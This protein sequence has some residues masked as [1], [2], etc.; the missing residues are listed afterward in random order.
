M[1]DLQIGL[2]VIGAVAVV[3]VVMFNR[4]QERKAHREAQRA[5]GSGHADVLLEGSPSREDPHLQRDGLQSAGAMPDE[6]IDY[7]IVLRAPVGVP[8]ASALEPWRP[9]EQRFSRRVLLAGSD[10]SGWRRIGQG[11]FGSFNAM[12][13]SLQLVSRAGVVGDAELVEFRAEVETLA[14]RVGASVAAPEMRAALE[15]ARELDRV[16][17]EADIQVAVHA[18]GPPV[19]GDF[20]GRPFQ[21]TPGENG[22]TLTLDVARTLEPARAFEAMV[23]AARQLSG[24]PGKLVDDN[25]NPLDDRALAGIGAQ[26]EGVRA[27]LAERGIEPGSPLALRLF[28]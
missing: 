23:R 2:V 20:A 14:T 7:I 11:E 9:I 3:G 21:V 16:C 19:T 18:V 10:G 26:I 27:M 12:R 6:R 17:A 1:T 4:I 8:G 15:A 28:S 24:D 25:G 13:A 22:A 5:F